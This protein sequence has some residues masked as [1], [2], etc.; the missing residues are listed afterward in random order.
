MKVVES[1]IYNTLAAL[2]SQFGFSLTLA[3]LFMFLYL[4]MKEIGI[5]NALKKWVSCFRSDKIFRKIFLLA[6]YVSMVIFYTLFNRELWMN[7]LSKI[8]GGWG[9]YDEEGKLTTEAV[10]NV[11]LFI[12][13]ISVL[14]WAFYKEIFKG[15]ITLFRLMGKSLFI[16]FVSSL[17][18]EFCQLVLRVGT[19]QLSDLFYNTLGGFIGGFIYWVG[20]RISNRNKKKQ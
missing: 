11:I 6:F 14:F 8:M 17:V 2:Y 13:Y 18:I 1:I 10:E 9:F 3:I 12:P 15:K 4:Y 19:F 16:S 7:P 5:K 20:Y